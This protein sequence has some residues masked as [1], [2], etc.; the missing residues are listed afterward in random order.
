MRLLITSSHRRSAGLLFVAF[1]ACLALAGCGA[2]EDDPLGVNS[3]G[4]T[5]AEVAV[6]GTKTDPVGSGVSEDPLNVGADGAA[7]CGVQPKD[8]RLSY[9]VMLHNPTLETFTFGEMALGDPE[10]LTVL[11]AKVQTANREGH[12]HGGAAKGGHDAHAAAPTPTKAPEPIGPPVEAEGFELEPDAHVNIIVTVELAE[13]ASHGHAENI[14][15]AFSSAEREY[16][17]P[18][19]LTIDVDAASCT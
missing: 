16:A 15:V 4:K 17:V 5:S 10:D 13:G 8:S 11:S 18:H 1:S 9:T 19:P 14:V 7:L 12:H 3:A 6:N 2:A